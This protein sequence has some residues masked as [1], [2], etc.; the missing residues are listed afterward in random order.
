MP[1]ADHMR[2]LVLNFETFKVLKD[3]VMRWPEESSLSILQPEVVELL[4]YKFIRQNQA[5]GKYLPTEA[6]VYHITPGHLKK[7]A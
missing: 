7:R 4:E 5:T 6:G 2:R 3:V 1:D